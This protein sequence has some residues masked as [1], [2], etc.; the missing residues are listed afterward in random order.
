LSPAIYI[1]IYMPIFILFFVILPQ[2]RGMQKSIILKIKKRKGLM[3]MTNEVI[4]KYIGK[5]CRI[6]TGSFGTNLIGQI[7]SVN[8]NW[9]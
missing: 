7:I 4:K 2:E 3:I 8:E 9:I 6:S 1:A 5:N